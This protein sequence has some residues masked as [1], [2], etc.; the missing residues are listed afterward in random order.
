MQVQ[1]AVRTMVNA[2]LG[3]RRAVELMADVHNAM[4]QT[5]IEYEADI[6]AH[7]QHRG[8]T[9]AIQGNP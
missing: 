7:I 5:S 4:A 8:S 2:V 1:N 6:A 9:H 3:S